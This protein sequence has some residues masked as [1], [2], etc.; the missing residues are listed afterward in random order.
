MPTTILTVTSTTP[1]PID[2]WTVTTDLQSNA[3]LASGF[4]IGDTMLVTG[5]I[6]TEETTSWFVGLNEE[7]PTSGTYVKRWLS[8]ATGPVLP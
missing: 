1:D 8:N 2:N 3:P 5:V 7:P 4:E 6:G